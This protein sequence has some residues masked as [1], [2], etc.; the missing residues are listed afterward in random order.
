MNRNR[1]VA[2]FAIL[3]VMVCVGCSVS[4][5]SKSKP[6]TQ[7]SV[8]SYVKELMPLVENTVGRKFKRMP[9][10]RIVTTDELVK[11][12]FDWRVSAYRKLHPN[13]SEYA[14]MNQAKEESE[15]YRT[16]IM[17]AASKLDGIIYFLPAVL[18]ENAKDA[19]I[20]SDDEAKFAKVVM[21]HEVAHALRD[22]YIKWN[23]YK[24]SAE[25]GD[26]E[27]AADAVEEGFAGFVEDSVVK[28][29]GLEKVQ[30]QY[31]DNTLALK[32]PAA[33][34]KSLG[35]GTMDGGIYNK[36]CYLDGRDFI[37]WHYKNHGIKYVWHIL[38]NP[39]ATSAMIYHPE[40]YSPAIPPS[41]D[42][43]KVF[44][45]IEKYFGKRHW[46]RDQGQGDIGAGAILLRAGLAPRLP[47]KAGQAMRYADYLNS[48]EMQAGDSYICAQLYMMDSPAH[49][50]Q[51]ADAYEQYCM[52]KHIKD[53]PVLTKFDGV[54]ADS[55]TKWSCVEKKDHKKITHERFTVVR[56]KAVLS[57]K[58]ENVDMQSKQLIS[59]FN[60]M[61]DRMPKETLSG[62]QKGLIH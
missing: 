50:R 27:R 49:A 2:I 17:A 15:Y 11:Y 40:T 52:K 34:S 54:E 55:A 37:A 60:A 47:G 9:G 29:L 48:V 10:V 28:R 35:A 61:F 33:E 13:A 23:A 38:A 30:R 7:A 58:L 46:K 12:E 44:N 59:A 32:S 24:T 5:K 51:F 43:S 41:Q 56:G 31:I 1:L 3:V 25:S 39:P 8:E 21:A 45:G 42:Y 36:F 19:K 22:Q 14:I 26:A 6:L 57:I 4:H 20:S 62:D 53:N 18:R 16:G